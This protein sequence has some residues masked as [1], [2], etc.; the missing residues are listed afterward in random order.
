MLPFSPQL[1][2]AS[3]KIYFFQYFYPVP[4][5]HLSTKNYKAY[6]S[7]KHSL[8]RQQASEPELDVA[9]MLELSDQEY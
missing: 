5:V 9:G 2:T 3:L 6:K 7:Q 4:H 1:T 8:K